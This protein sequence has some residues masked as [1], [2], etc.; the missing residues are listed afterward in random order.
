MIPKVPLT[1]TATSA[2]FL[3]FPG[4]AQLKPCMMV[5]ANTKLDRRLADCLVPYL[6]RVKVGSIT[7]GAG[8]TVQRFLCFFLVAVE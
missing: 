6:K 8:T 7:N 4:K 5:S 1:A 3:A 2:I